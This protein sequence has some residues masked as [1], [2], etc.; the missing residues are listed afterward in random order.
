MPTRASGNY[1]SWATP[2]HAPVVCLRYGAGEVI[3][4]RKPPARAASSPCFRV[5]PPAPL[6]RSRA[7]PLLSSSGGRGPFLPH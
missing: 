3:S 7:R 5:A 1:G 2:P 4:V 6:P